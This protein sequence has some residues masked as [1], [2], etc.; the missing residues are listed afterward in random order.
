[1]FTLGRDRDQDLLFPVVPV[2]FPS[3]VPGL[4]PVQYEYTISLGNLIVFKKHLNAMNL[5]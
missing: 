5:V 4:I 2:P 3:T 1:M